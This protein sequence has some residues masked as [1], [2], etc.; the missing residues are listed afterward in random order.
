MLFFRTLGRLELSNTEGG[1]AS[2]LLNQPK[3]L[4]LLAYLAFNAPRGSVRRDSLLPLFWPELDMDRARRALR[5]TIH[6]LRSTVGTDIVVVRGEED[7][8]V[9]AGKLWC[10]GVA[11]EE[12][13]REDRLAEAL[14]LYTG[15]AFPGLFV[16]DAPE[17]ENWLE[18]TRA[19]L[20][21]RAAQAAL[22]LAQNERDAGHRDVAIKWF[23]RASDLAPT[24]ELPIRSLVEL[25][26]HAGNRASAVSAYE[27]FATRLRTVYEL[28]PSPETAEFVERVRNRSGVINPTAARPAAFAAD[29]ESTQTFSATRRSRSMLQAVAVGVLAFSVGGWAMWEH[30]AGKPD[31]PDLSVGVL[32]FTD[33]TRGGGEQYLSDGMTEELITK[34]SKVDGLLVPARTSSFVFKDVRKDISGIARQLGVSH[35]LEGSVRRDGRRVRVTAQ[36]ID[37]RTGY[38]IW[39]EN[40]DRNLDDLLKLQ[41]DIAIAIASALKLRLVTDAATNNTPRGA[42]DLDAYDLYLKGRYYWN[43]RNAEGLTKAIS[44]LSA[45]V[46]RDSNYAAAYSALADAYQLAPTFAAMPPDEAFPKARAAALHALQLD[47]TSAE[48]HASLGYIKM[49]WN[50]DW[51][52]SEASLR[53]AIELNPGYATAYQ[54]LRLNLLARGH[55]TEALAAALRAQRLD[56]LSPS[57]QAAVGDTYLYNRQYAL[58]VGPYQKAIKLDS[59]YERALVGLTRAYLYGGRMREAERAQRVAADLMDGN[60]YFSALLAGTYG[61][62]GKKKEALAILATLRA[63]SAKQYVPA[64]AFAA[65]HASLAHQDSA[66]YWLQRAA[67]THE[68]FTTF[69][70]VE[71]AFDAIRK[72]PEYRTVV[73]AMGLD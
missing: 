27:E 57:I 17:F 26:D 41:D 38:H 33:M 10:D 61:A 21:R 69:I 19:T 29:P 60:S 68:T 5:Q 56:P 52:G 63:Q 45:A 24:D 16:P 62:M 58:A 37:A 48:A 42:T 30:W 51:R 12:L 35:I 1:D 7:V 55:G 15:D 67:E 49:Q 43:Q 66:L 28:E 46:E 25:L 13:L 6:V 72:R 47:S 34:L 50:R 70:P 3:R 39:S 44:Y 40:Y 59:H 11:F 64:Y 14:E 9:D 54:W 73:M 31:A 32:P 23:R 20:R 71:P 8:A 4:G 22:R 2:R 36:L 18:E 53:R 65:V